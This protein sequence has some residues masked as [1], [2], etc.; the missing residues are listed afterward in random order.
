MPAPSPCVGV[1]P[2]QHTP[3]LLACPQLLRLQQ[4]RRR[5]VNL[6]DVGVGGWGGGEQ[7]IDTQCGI[8]TSSVC[9]SKAIS[10]VGAGRSIWGSG[11]QGVG[12]QC[13]RRSSSMC[14]DKVKGMCTSE[15]R[16]QE[17]AHPQTSAYHMTTDLQCG[18]CKPPPP[19]HHS[20]PQAH[21]S[22]LTWSGPSPMAAP[23]LPQTTRACIAA[24]VRRPRP[25]S[26]PPPS[27]RPGRRPWQHTAG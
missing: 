22:P 3:Q 6:G 26:Q 11:S 16:A 9:L 1:G 12:T 15:A 21:H 8:W 20:P 14:F 23:H 10:K 25:S 7:G 13:G 24:F 5:Q 18:C 2:H 19:P 27:P 4:R 17:P